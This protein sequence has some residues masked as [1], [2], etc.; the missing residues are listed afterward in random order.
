MPGSHEDQHVL[1]RL[2]QRH[3]SLGGFQ[4]LLHPLP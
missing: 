3:F 2:G 4:D 1:E